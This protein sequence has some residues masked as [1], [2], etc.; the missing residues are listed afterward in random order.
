MERISLLN[1][2]LCPLLLQ[3]PPA[4]E[5]RH[6]DL[7][8]DFLLSL[9]KGYHFVG[10]VRNK[11]LLENSL[12]SL[13][14]KNNVALIII[15]HPFLPELSVTTSDFTYIRWEGVRGKVKGTLGKDELDRSN[16][17]TR[18]VEKI[19]KFLDHSIEVFGYFSKYYSGH[20][21]SNVAQLLSQLQ[22]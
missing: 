3:L 16:D 1:G 2:K 5:Y 18:W 11:K 4:F 7:L 8:K 19:E 22:R 12:Y 15:D 10:E 13:L 20:P 14:R 6:L 17:I 9:P 21:P